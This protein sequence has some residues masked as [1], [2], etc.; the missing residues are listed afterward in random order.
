MAA[1]LLD[2]LVRSRRPRRILEIGTSYGYAACVLG[3]AAAGYDGSVLT[4]EKEPRLVDAARANLAA[5][6]LTQWVEVREGD[7]RELV[8]AL[9]G[10]FGL[11]VQDGGKDDYLPL[12]DTLVA[13]LEPGGL[14]FTDDVLF[15][16]MPLPPAVQHWQGAVASY[17]AALAADPRLH[18]VWLPIGDGVALSV[19]LPY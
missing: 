6:G 5:A 17:N 12:L 3:R 7:A 19:R 13:R 11:I 15:P 1:A 9:E 2:V 10:S 18:T 8:P 14:L 16:V 4:L